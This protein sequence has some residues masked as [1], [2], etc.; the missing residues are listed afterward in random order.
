M[1][2]KIIDITCQ[3]VKACAQFNYRGHTISFSTI[4][5]GVDVFV[6]IDGA[7]SPSDMFFKTVHDAIEWINL[8]S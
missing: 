3:S 5:K 7:S 1:D 4:M 6:F 2:Y 8:R